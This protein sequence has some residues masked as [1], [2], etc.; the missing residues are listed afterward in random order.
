M[1]SIFLI[2][3]SVLCCM[4]SQ[5]QSSLSGNPYLT[6]QWMYSFHIDPF[7]YMNMM[8]LWLSNDEPNL[9]DQLGPFDEAFGPQNYLT[10]DEGEKDYFIYRKNKKSDI[11]YFKILKENTDY[12]ILCDED[13]DICDCKAG[14]FLF[15]K[16][17]QQLQRIEKAFSFSLKKNLV[18]RLS[19][20]SLPVPQHWEQ[21]GFCQIL[22]EL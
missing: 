6:N 14:T 9:K 5:A 7:S 8:N 11:R 15:F 16:N 2:L 12:F 1:K 21:L 13:N 20:R 10:F 17:G 18:E 3:F 22:R 19:A 4:P